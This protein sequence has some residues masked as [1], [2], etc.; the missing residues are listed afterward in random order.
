VQRRCLQGERP[1]LRR[2]APPAGS[3][4]DRTEVSPFRFRQ[5]WRR[6]TGHRPSAC[7][8]LWGGLTGRWRGCVCPTAGPS[9]VPWPTSRSGTAS[10]CA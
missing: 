5:P 7:A 3:L 2:G 4:V 10:G 1:G 9:R 6:V 8:G